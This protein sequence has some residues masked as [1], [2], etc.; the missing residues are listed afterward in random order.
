MDIGIDGVESL[1]LKFVGGNLVHQSDAASLLLHIDDD[2]LA[3]FVNGLHGL[4]ELFAA[5]ATL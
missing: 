3:F 1:F 5:V 4:M 2:A